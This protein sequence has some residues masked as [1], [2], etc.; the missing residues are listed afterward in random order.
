MTR[1]QAALL[2]LTGIAL[3]AGSALALAHEG[4]SEPESRSLPPAVQSLLRK[5][6]VPESSLAVFAQEVTSDRPLLATGADAPMNPA[7]VIKLLTTYVALEALGP[8]YTWKTS[9]YTTGNLRAGR[10]EGD[11]Y[12]KGGGDPFLVTERFWKLLLRLRNTGVRDIAGDLV[13]DNSWF[14]IESEDPGEFDGRPYRAYN[15]APDA[16]LLNFGVTRFWFVPDPEAGEVRIVPEPPSTTLKIENLMSL[17]SSGCVGGLKHLNMRV[18]SREDGGTVRFSGAYPAKCGRYSISRAIATPVPFAFGAFQAMWRDL[19][20]TI[21]G[22]VR[23]ADTPP[24]A[25]LIY[26]LDSLTLAELIRPTNKFSN[27]VMSRQLLLTLGAERKG[28]PGT[29][30][31]GRAAVEEWLRRARLEFPELILDNGAGLS[32][33]TRVTA[34]SLGELLLH[35]YRSPYMSEFIASLPLSAIDGTLKRRFHRGP[36]ARQLHLKTGT[37]DNVRAMGGYLRTRSGRTFVVVSLHNYRGIHHGFGTYIQDEL[38][39]WLYER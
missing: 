19:G 6:K 28:P 10:L 23:V 20:G 3:L 32:R 31:K 18:M 39:R 2:G 14:E 21:E 29:V 13:I 22:G 27:N 5:Q 26:S 1:L 12:L 9:V 25:E 35:A 8:A 15:V 34:R 11:L 16:L 38:L 36:L 37:L 30:E 4:E 24:E 7:S 17:T 33:E